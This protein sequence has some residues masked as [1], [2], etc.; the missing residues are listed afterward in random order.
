MPSLSVTISSSKLSTTGQT[1]LGTTGTTVPTLGR[2][3]PAGTARNP[4]YS[5]SFA[6]TA[7]VPA[8]PP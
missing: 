7:F 6:R 5:L 4:W 3:S 8:M 2:D 1:W